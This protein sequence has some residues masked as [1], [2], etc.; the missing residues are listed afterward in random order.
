MR[1]R[2][3]KVTQ[4]LDKSR[5]AMTLY[6][7]IIIRDAA[8][9]VVEDTGEQPSYS[10]TFQFIR[11]LESWMRNNQTLTAQ[12][13][14]DTSRILNMPG[15]AAITDDLTYQAMHVAAGED[16]DAY[17]IL[18]GTDD[19]AEANDDVAL[20]AKI[21][22]GNGAG[23]LEHGPMS[24]VTPRVNGSYVDYVLIRN[25]YNNSGSPITSKEFAIY[26]KRYAAGAW[27][28]YFCFI[29]DTDAVGK[30]V[31]HGDTMT[32]QYTL[33]VGAGFVLNWWLLL[34]NW[35]EAPTGGGTYNS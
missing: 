34:G 1:D 21:A 31:E 9:R 24:F 23:Q 5:G 27:P 17:G 29:R 25:F 3:G 28:K 19:T 11:L 6:K 32:V 26:T 16:D 33:R 12:D 35:F 2:H 8:G 10:Y 22:Q 30:T 18:V 4:V 7:R 20:T 15:S 13:V 14:T